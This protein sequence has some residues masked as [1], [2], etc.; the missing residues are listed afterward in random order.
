[1]FIYPLEGEH[2]WYRF[3]NLFGE[4][5]AHQR[6]A[7]IPQQEHDLHREASLAWLEMSNPHQALRH[8]KI[9]QDTDLLATI[10][11]KHGWSMFNQ[12][13]LEMLESSINLLSSNQLYSEPKLCML[14]AWLAQSQHRYNDVGA[15]LSKA[16][17]EMAKLNVEL[18]SK[19]QGE[20]NALRAQVAI[21]Q[22]E[23]EKALELA[24]LALSQL[25]NTIYRSRIVATSVVGEVNHV[26]G[27][28]SRALPMMQQTEKL[29][30][31]Y[32]VYH[33]ALWALLQQSEILIAQGYVQAAYEVQ[34]NAFKLIE[35][36]QLHQLP[37]HEFLL[38]VRAQILWCWNRLD[39]AEECAYKGL[40]VLGNHSP[41]K[42]LHSYSM[43]ARI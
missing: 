28:L 38:R 14:Q 11:S 18:S 6:L 20:F 5:L 16:D 29:A 36:H 12:G 17:E 31:Q 7:R 35:E 39:E 26:L 34:D 27:Q 1:L 21:N 22:N 42:H 40:D 25:D 41:S 13:E 3:H 4:F 33:Q 43:L 9:A 2:N 30:R 32:Q 10:L 24:E 8:A 19:E 15:L 37:L 23:P